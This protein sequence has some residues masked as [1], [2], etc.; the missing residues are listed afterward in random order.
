MTQ[1]TSPTAT[2]VPRGKKANGAAPIETAAPARSLE[3][4]RIDQVDI[5][6]NVRVKPGEL[7]ELAASIKAHGV[8]QPVRVV[9][10]HKDGRYRLVWGQRRLLAAKQAG[11][12]FIPAI[13]DSLTTSADV[14][15]P[16]A[17][18]SIEQLVENLHRADLNP[19]D[20]AKALRQVLDSDKGLTQVA[21][22]KKLGRSEPW[23][24]NSLRLLGLAPKVQELVSGGQLSQSHAKAIAG[25]TG[26]QAQLDV[27]ET[28]VKYDYS[29]KQ[30]ESQVKYRKQTDAGEP[31]RAAQIKKATER[32]A[33]KV[34][35]AATEAKLPA[36]A[37]LVASHY[38]TDAKLLAKLLKE[39]GYA[40]GGQGSYGYKAKDLEGFC[41]CTTYR[42]DDYPSAHV[43]HCCS[44]SKHTD[45]IKA[46]R[47]AAEASREKE[48][49]DKAKRLTTVLERGLAGVDPTA[50]RLAIAAI[51]GSNLTYQVIGNQKKGDPW[52]KLA[53]FADEKL[54]FE[55]AELIA[56]RLVPTDTYGRTDDSPG[57]ATTINKLAAAPAKKGKGAK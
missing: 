15:A 17:T 55:L 27:A 20:E 5:G 46:G 42:F 32:F 39:A 47:E 44:N 4:L 43:E 54:P 51:F 13:V 40:T 52:D 35:K 21:L 45:A 9:G 1:A 7:D 12:A 57:L 3:Q 34:I 31:D 23:V 30:V 11:L 19:I 48:L 36:G 41:D 56:E 50:A 53:A 49:K 8:L 2:A 26:K 10:P 6:A 28:A 37:T 29:A 14:D 22:A 33:K 25:L 16:G 38:D 18:R 24:A